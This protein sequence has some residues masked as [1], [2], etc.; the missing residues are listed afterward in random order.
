MYGSIYLGYMR[1]LS[2]ATQ[3]P[4]LGCPWE[5][6]APTLQAREPSASGLSGGSLEPSTHRSILSTEGPQCTREGL[7]MALKSEV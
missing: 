3:V 6:H 1:L 7:P 2:L 5:H 4:A